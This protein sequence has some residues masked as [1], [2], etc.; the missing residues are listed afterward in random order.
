MRLV[1]FKLFFLFVC[2]LLILLLVFSFFKGKIF[3]G[4]FCRS[5]SIHPYKN[6]CQKEIFAIAYLPKVC[7]L[8]K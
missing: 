7:L 6:I 2:M 8:N 4:I 3:Q 5:L 1:V